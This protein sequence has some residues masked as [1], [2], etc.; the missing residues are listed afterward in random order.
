[1]Q[2]ARSIGVAMLATLLAAGCG[3]GDGE[4]AAKTQESAKARPDATDP[5]S[6]KDA[7]AE[8]ASVKPTD[9]EA[10]LAS[11]VAD[12]KTTAPVDLLYDLPAK[13]EV[14]QP[15][16]VEFAVKPRVQADVLDVE[17]ADSPGLTIQGERQARFQAVE[18]G[19]PY[20]FQLQV[21]G[22]A[23]GLYY[24]S[25]TAKIAT[26]VQTEA[27]AFSVPVVIGSPAPVQK[28]APQKDASGQPIESLPAKEQ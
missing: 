8:V 11:A 2:M 25:V 14:G 27:R 17:V 22:N 16:T 1:M 6:S 5:A 7:T 10:R 9:K 19:Q 4:D 23:A 13:P 20:T 15:F 18:A 3:G 24:V 12:S 21:V 28:P 26:Q